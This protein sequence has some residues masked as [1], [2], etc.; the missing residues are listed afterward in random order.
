MWSSLNDEIS[1]ILNRLFWGNFG[2]FCW[3]FLPILWG[4][5]PTPI[6]CSVIPVDRLSG[7]FVWWGINRLNYF[8]LTILIWCGIASFFHRNIGSS[9]LFLQFTSSPTPPHNANRLGFQQ[10]NTLKLQGHALKLST[11]GATAFSLEIFFINGSFTRIL[12]S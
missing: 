3:K 4:L 10:V 12:F 5:I 6:A 9:A 2:V 1:V 8:I 7:S 11:P